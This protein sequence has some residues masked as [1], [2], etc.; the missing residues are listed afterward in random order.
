MKFIE[1]ILSFLIWLF[2]KRSVPKSFDIPIVK[3]PIVSEP[4]EGFKKEPGVR[5]VPEPDQDTNKLIGIFAPIGEVQRILVKSYG[6]ELVV[7][8]GF[9]A[10]TDWDKDADWTIGSGR[11]K[12]TF[13]GVGTKTSQPGILT[14]GKT[15]KVE[16]TLSLWIAGTF[17]MR[18]GTM[19]GSDRSADGTYIEEILC[20]INTDLAILSVNNGGRCSFDNVSATEITERWEDE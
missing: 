19:G 9:D 12:A 16:I 3:P 17:T 8:G 20:T 10:D 14:V 15:Y 18:C 13:T 11:L 1:Q 2:A 7:N 6:P 4:V 5:T